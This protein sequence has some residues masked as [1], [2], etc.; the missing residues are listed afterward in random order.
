MSTGDVHVGAGVHEARAFASAT[1]PIAV[2]DRSGLRESLGFSARPTLL[3]VGH[4][5]ERKGHHLVIEAMRDLPDMELVIEE[6]RQDLITLE[7]VEGAA[8]AESSLEAGG[9]LL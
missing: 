3:S 6:I 2:A 8:A 5:I 7:F 1:A 4:L 9:A